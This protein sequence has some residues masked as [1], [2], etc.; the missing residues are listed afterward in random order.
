MYRQQQG[1][2]CTRQWCQRCQCDQPQT[3]WKTCP[4]SPNSQMEAEDTILSSMDDAVGRPKKLAKKLPKEEGSSCWWQVPLY[5]GTWYGGS[6]LESATR[7]LLSWTGHV[8]LRATIESTDLIA[9]ENMTAL[10]SLFA[11]S[12]NVSCMAWAGSP[13]A[14]Q[15]VL[16]EAYDSAWTEW[17]VSRQRRGKLISL[18]I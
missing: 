17:R 10:R 2:V 9:V 13:S 5:R 8:M 3:A 7:R 1:S 18:R 15:L 12:Y 14:V 6:V 11:N 16:Y 4:S